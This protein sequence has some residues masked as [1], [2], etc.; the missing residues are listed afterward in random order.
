MSIFN[1]ARQQTW[2]ELKGLSDEEFNQ[3]PAADEW[4]V[5]EV[6]DH[7][8]K[9]DE[10]AQSLLS[11]QA[12]DAPF[13]K[14][15]EKPME[16]IE[17]RT[18]KRPAPSQLEPEQNRISVIEA[19]QELDTARQQLTAV[20]SSLNEEDFE[21]VLP[22]PVFQELTIRQWIDFIGHHEKRHINQIKEIK[23]KIEKV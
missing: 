3:K 19:K 6:L 22:H 16:F 14:I 18:N 23:Q 2:E 5:R 1:E 12:K 4:S 8:K 15:E 13:K 21:R 11:K 17:D 20:I 10:S 7:L 9:I